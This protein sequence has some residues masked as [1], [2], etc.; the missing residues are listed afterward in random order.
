MMNEMA[1]RR[2]YER[3]EEA[4]KLYHVIRDL[5]GKEI[6]NMVMSIQSVGHGI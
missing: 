1:Y 3:E 2:H 6:K 4:R 5:Y